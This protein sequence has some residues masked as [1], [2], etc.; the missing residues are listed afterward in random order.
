VITSR[1]TIPSLGSMKLSITEDEGEQHS[2][3]CTALGWCSAS[4]LYTC[5][6]DESIVKWSIGSALHKGMGPGSAT[7]KV[8]T[9]DG[10]YISDMHWFPSSK[11]GQ[12]AGGSDLFVVSCT[13]GRFRLVSKAG[14]V[15]KAVDAHKGAVVSVRW[16]YEGTALA[17]C[18]EDGVI[19]VWSRAG[20]HRS[21]LAQMES[22]VYALCWG[23]DSD[24]LLFSCG[25][26]L[27]I[28]PLQPSAKQ[29]RWKAHEAAVL[30]V[31]WNPVNNL[32][33]SAGEDCRYKVWD[34]YGRLMF[35]S[36]QYDYAITSVAWAPNGETFAVGSFNLMRICDKTGWSMCR[37]ST[38]TGSLVN[39]AWTADGTHLAGAG[40]NGT[41]CFGQL[42]ERRLE[43]GQLEV[44]QT[45][46]D[47]LETLDI[48]S[49]AVEPLELRDRI[50][51]I[52]MG[53]GYLVV[54]TLT[55]IC[56]YE[57][58]AQEW[59]T[60]HVIDLKDTPTLL[61]QCERYFVSV[62]SYSGV[63]IFNYEGRQVSNPR[64]QGLRSEFL[65]VRSVSISNDYLAIIDR[66]D[67][68]VV[69][70][71]D[72]ASGKPLAHSITHTLEV[73][74]IGVSQHGLA[75]DRKL[76]VL[77][78]N[79]DLYIALIN[80][81]SAAAGGKGGRKGPAVPSMIKLASMVDC[82]IW[83]DT[84]DMLA[85]V[86]DSKVT[87]WYYPNVVYVDKDLL[88]ST[89]ETHMALGDLGKTP[90]FVNFSG[91]RVTPRRTD[92][93]LVT[94]GLSPY[95][96]LLF[97]H[98]A[99]GNWEHAIRLCR[100]VK[101]KPLWAC[102][103]AMAINGKELNAA[104]V[105][106][107]AIDEVDKVQFILHIKEI[108]TSEGRN[109][110]I[111]LFRRRPHEAETIL[112]QSSLYY[113]AIKMWIRLYNW[114]RALE[115]AVTHTTHVDTVLMHRQRYLKMVD[116][117]ETNK[118]FLQYR[119]KIEIDEEKIEAKVAAEKEKEAKRDDAR[120]YK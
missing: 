112:L 67:S 18:G 51:N 4:E 34:S 77:D 110:E 26:H 23:P 61:L 13:D 102:L 6:D 25:K 48:T 36:S 24:Q 116:K 119:D 22:A 73:L 57:R 88:N 79:H 42:L 94:I 11:K 5:S 28:K 85:A 91:T 27:V 12:S 20:M 3:I 71:I 69:R 66:G 118:H 98:V 64:F 17:T 35:T 90:Q 56:V 84:T 1:R 100:F 120:E 107:A 31:D 29:I 15:E 32:L 52:S 10:V 8:T 33:V 92:G 2:K 72:V 62:D 49:E 40:G 44:V 53:F 55:Q 95:P 106:Y 70:I 99:D 39:L 46:S 113:R 81:P 93:T 38:H 41:V 21:T 74:Q 103:A 63:Q 50:C 111:A 60:P 59:S 117:E 58:M 105:A 75:I 108:P 37:A 65:N 54:A 7:E 16:N 80:P 78:R 104:E 47:Q 19:K 109:A 101:D 9:I 45:T 14:R 43:W 76:Y 86:C 83:H 97:Q 115:L 89:K 87:V 30:K 96:P 68:R 82:A 114:D